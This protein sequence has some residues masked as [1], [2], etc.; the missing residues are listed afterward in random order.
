[1]RFFNWIKEHIGEGIILLIL[2]LLIQYLFTGFLVPDLREQLLVIIVVL[3][4]IM[5]IVFLVMA[6]RNKLQF[7]MG[8]RNLI[9][10]KSD[11]IIAILGFM[12]GTSI[13]CSSLAIGDTMGNMIE[14]L[15]YEQ[16]DLRD[17][18]ITVMNETGANYMF[19]GEGAT[20]ISDLIWSINEDRGEPLIDGVSWELELTGSI[21]NSNTLLFEPVIDFRAYSKETESSFGSLTKDGKR[22]EYDLGMDEVYIT[23][24]VAKLI[25]GEK[26]H[27][28]VISSGARQKNFT[29]AEVID[30]E[31][32]A[33]WSQNSIFFSFESLWDLYSI[34]N[35]TT[36]TPGSGRDWSGGAYNILFISNQGGRVQGGE[37]CDEAVKEINKKLEA[38]RNPVDQRKS[39]EVTGDKKTMV[40]MATDM[41]SQFTTMFLA[42]GMF[43]IIAG[44][45]LIINIFVMLSEERKEEMGISRA[46]GMKRRHLRTMY[47]F[48]G[49]LYS[50]LSSFVGVILGVAT[51]YLIILA[52]QKILESFAGDSFDIIQYYT[53]TPVSLV[54]AFVGGFAI[55]LGTT[56]FITQRIAKLN[57]VS[58]IRNTPVPVKKF[59]L[60][61]LGWK[62]FSVWD[63][64]KKDS[65]G[66]RTAKILNFVLDKLVLLGFAMVTVGILLY[67]YGTLKEAA[68]PV[69]LG[70]SLSIIGLGLLI[71]FFVNERIT[72][73]IIAILVLAFWIAPSPPAWENY[74]GNLEM[75][76]L[77]GIFM[78]SSGV[79]LLVWN[80]DIIL[81]IVEKAVCTVKMSPAS[82]KMAISYPIKKRFRTG[83]TIF[84]FALII[85]TI[86]GLSMIVHTF[87][88][89]IKEFEKSVGGGYEIIGISAASGIPD[90]EG[91]LINTDIHGD[92]DWD[93]TVSLSSGLLFVNITL[94]DNSHEEIPASSTG[95]PDKFIEKNQYGFN[96]VAWDLIDPEKETKREDRTVWEALKTNGSWVI[97][98]SSFGENEFG[99][100]GM[101][102][103]AEIGKNITVVSVNGTVY[104]KTV[105]GICKLIGF[106]SVFQYEPYA[107]TD[108]LSTEKSTHMIK[109]KDNRDPREVANAM[110]KELI[111]YGFFTIVVEELMQEILEVQNNFFNLFNAFLS[112]GLV[113]GI[114]GL[115]IVTLRS[116]YE[117]RHEI[118]MMRAIGF[119]RHMVIMAF[120]GESGFIA[121]SGVLI[122]TAL[123]IILG[124]MLWRDGL[125]DALP[126][127]GV[128]WLNLILIGGIT[129]IVALLS[130]IPPAYKAS[131][132]TPADALRYE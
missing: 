31:G 11:T 49:T 122:G 16:Y 81:W 51:G 18:Y 42:L 50:L 105:I 26:G 127:F 8:F 78:V 48:E 2:L 62:L 24:E 21:I 99:P 66:S 128:P 75:F 60:V 58:A 95:V 93:R 12:I 61:I 89:N 126:N 17:E 132:V 9:R 98:D 92:I 54:L 67:Y 118:G 65:D 106:V 112:L 4:L 10:H 86:T 91:G 79:L 64:E 108:F 103:L 45:A 63:E 82:I 30:N 32:R 19:D 94:P 33:A 97:V 6:L 73:N 85:F 70:L 84:M 87:N 59:K 96:E 77:S 56:I 116:V 27:Q 40:D 102:G 15:V 74:S 7:K 20:V 123:G 121:G 117:R 47:L 37:L 14:T 69:Y 88:V 114:V 80:T 55:T 90:L 109:I 43:S 68:W 35:I 36:E 124:W 115:G 46:V 3:L 22:L 107:K 131:R 28:L 52:V 110:R 76:I 39:L 100:P 13:I 83:V 111:R 104:N 34:E 53:V 113:I 25:D 101:T 125:S 72:Y 44:I 29:V 1:M 129:F 38:V 5:G 120:L 23:K 119:K 130:T 41:M 71:R 57:I